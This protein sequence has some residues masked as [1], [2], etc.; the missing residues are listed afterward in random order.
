[1][2]VGVQAASLDSVYQEALLDALLD[3][4]GAKAAD[5]ESRRWASAAMRM[6]V[7]ST[8]LPRKVTIL[9]RLRDEVYRLGLRNLGSTAG[10]R[11]GLLLC[12]AALIDSVLSSSPLHAEEISLKLE[13][14]NRAKLT[15]SLEGRA[16]VDLEVAMEGVSTFIESLAQLRALT[17]SNFE[18]KRVSFTGQMLPIVDRCVVASERPL[19]VE[20][21]S[22]ATVAVFSLL[23]ESDRTALLERWLDAKEQKHA[24]LVCKGRLRA[25]S[26]L[27]FVCANQE[28][29]LRIVQ[30]LE[31]LVKG[32]VAI[33]VKTSAMESLSVLL[34][35]SASQS[36]APIKTLGDTLISGLT[37]Y[38]NDQR[39]DVGS[40]LR[41][42]SLEAAEILPGTQSD[43]AIK[44]RV[45]TML[46][47][48]VIRLAAEKFSK[49]RYRAWHSLGKL[50][51]SPHYG[52]E[53]AASFDHLEDVSTEG[54]YRH[55]LEL[56]TIESLREPL[57]VG[58]CSSIGGPEDVNRACCSA[59]TSLAINKK[60]NERTLFV[61]SVI[62]TLLKYLDKLA[63]GEDHDIVPVVE[64][65]T[66][67][68]NQDLVTEAS[69]QTEEVNIWNVVQKVHVSTSGIERIDAVVR[70]CS[71]LESFATLRTRALDK[72]TRQLLHRYP[73]VR[74]AAAD[75]LYASCLNE[76][77]L[78][79]DWNA[80]SA[81]NKSLVLDLRKTLKVAKATAS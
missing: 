4:R 49:V 66:F 38:T 73:R 1:M 17:G 50:W 68:L 63:P 12:T 36:D 19:S 47:P 67:I 39:G 13:S 11:H 18:F 33:E 57:V 55:L 80:P 53:L 41:L 71:A 69:L 54:Y 9:L 81:L 30:F 27:H 58:L 59:F 65:L 70:L 44:L 32:S 29:G 21:S 79:A 7:V 64:F 51:S 6:L 22:R 43:K 60:G 46:V 42:Q 34:R 52:K 75:I 24:D 31:E 5:A 77:L 8:K 10:A 56:L 25:L 62:T 72:M 45:S 15:G 23:D 78:R 2:E 37:D 40:L 74:N 3:W 16:T 35:P 76:D 61:R 28:L 26:N 48:Y 20:A 14:F